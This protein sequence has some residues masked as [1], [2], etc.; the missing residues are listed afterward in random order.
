MRSLPRAYAPD[1]R[2]AG[3]RERGFKGLSR[4]ALERRRLVL[5]GNAC[6]DGG[7]S[8]PD[9]ARSLGHARSLTA[10]KRP[11]SF[12]FNMVVLVARLPVNK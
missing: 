4:G 6:R 9:W 7:Y 8:R 5:G 1:A 10:T 12:F 11:S 3:M 2:V